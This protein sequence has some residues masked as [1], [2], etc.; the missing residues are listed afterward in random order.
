[1]AGSVN[2]VGLSTVDRVRCGRS[3]LCHTSATA[4]QQTIVKK[5]VSTP[6]QPISVPIVGY[7]E[8]KLAGRA[9]A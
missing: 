8:G 9:P 6:T 3:V 7:W 2:L 1:M 5:V 4:I